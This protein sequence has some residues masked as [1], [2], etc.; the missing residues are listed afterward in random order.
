MV[1]KEGPMDIS[2]FDQKNNLQRLLVPGILFSWATFCFLIITYFFFQP[3]NILLDRKYRILF[4]FYLSIFTLS[5]FWIY[6]RPIDLSRLIIIMFPISS[7]LL[8]IQSFFSLLRLNFSRRNALIILFS[9]CLI[10]SIGLIGKT[11][12]NTYQIDELAIPIGEVFFFCDLRGFCNYVFG[13]SGK[14]WLQFF[15]LFL[16][17]ILVVYISFIIYGKENREQYF[18]RFISFVVTGVGGVGL[19]VIIY[20]VTSWGIM[21]SSAIARAY[22]GDTESMFLVGK[23]LAKQNENRLSHE[24]FKWIYQAAENGHPGAQ[25]IVGES[26]SQFL[27]NPRSNAVDQDKAKEWL[28]TSSELG[29]K[30]AKYLLGLYYLVGGERNKGLELIFESARLGEQAAQLYV[31]DLYRYGSEGYERSF[32]KAQEWYWLAAKDG[33]PRAEQLCTPLPVVAPWNRKIKKIKR[34]S[35][36]GN[37]ASQYELAIAIEHRVGGV[38]EQ[39]FELL[40]AAANG[41]HTDAKVL[42][43]YALSSIANYAERIDK[44]DE[45]AVEWLKQASADGSAKAMYMLGLHYISGNGIAKNQENGM[46]QIE[47]AAKK[48]FAA[49]N[50]YYG[51]LYRYGKNGFKRNFKTAQEWYCRAAKAGHPNAVNLCK[52]LPLIESWDEVQELFLHAKSGHAKSQY[53]LACAIERRVG[54]VSEQVFE[55]LLAAANGGHTDAKVLVGYALSSIANYA[56]RIDKD[57]ERAV[58]WLKQASADG[59]AKAMYLLGEHYLSGTGVRRDEAKRERLIRRAAMLEKQ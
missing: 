24:S 39:V 28:R 45:R 27:D 12:Y 34:L 5:N 25:C 57:D 16:M 46:K 4:I 36:D 54:G 19:L 18:R 41:G 10:I 9:A 51:D 31:G 55:L 47:N 58:E 23:L 3:S 15:I 53:M 37:A 29:N 20:I 50:F 44:D 17:V 14:V 42:V 11:I 1:F 32:H 21:Y 49:A 35:D 52:P 30:R 13:N 59:S 56:E 2:V 40:L 33:N 22:E 48:G 43:G 38:S 26:Y 7:I 8:I 6:S